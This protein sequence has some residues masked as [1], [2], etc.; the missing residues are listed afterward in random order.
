VA[1]LDQ[2]GE[3]LGRDEQVAGIVAGCIRLQLPALWLQKGVI[4]RAAAI[5]TFMDRCRFRA[6]EALGQPRKA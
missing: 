4:D 5:F 3:V 6:R 2:L 1:A